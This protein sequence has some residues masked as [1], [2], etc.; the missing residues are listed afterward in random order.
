MV[1]FLVA[2]VQPDGIGLLV[3]L[4]TVITNV[5]SLTEVATSVL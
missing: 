3:E 5:S 4:V 1:F 2:Q